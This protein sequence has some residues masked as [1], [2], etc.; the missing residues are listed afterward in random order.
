MDL[1]TC[2]LNYEDETATNSSA[3]ELEL[4]TIT[5]ILGTMLQSDEEPEWEETHRELLF[6]VT[7]HHCCESWGCLSSSGHSFR[8]RKPSF[9]SELGLV[10]CELSSQNIVEPVSIERYAPNVEIDPHTLMPVSRAAEYLG[11][12]KRTLNKWRLTG[13]GTQFAKLGRRIFYRPA[14]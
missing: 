12:S 8:Q 10:L 6:P 1:R 4:V 2:P 9:F 7:S 14:T 5:I 13:D 11:L 3:G